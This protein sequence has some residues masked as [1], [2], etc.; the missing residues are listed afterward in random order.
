MI[1][2]FEIKKKNQNLSKY[3]LSLRK[4]NNFQITDCSFYKYS[5][6]H[7][8][9]TICLVQKTLPISNESSISAIRGFQY[10]QPILCVFTKYQVR[11]IPYLNFNE[12]ALKYPYFH[13]IW[14][15]HQ[16]ASAPEESPL[17]ADMASSE[18][19]AMT[20]VCLGVTQP[21]C[22][23]QC[24]HQTSGAVLTS[25]AIFNKLK[26]ASV[27]NKCT[28]ASAGIFHKQLSIYIVLFIYAYMLGWKIHKISGNDFTLGHRDQ[29]HS[30]LLLH[31][32]SLSYTISSIYSQICWGILT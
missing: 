3:P 27:W 1:P 21:N 28:T 8:T 2:F 20:V 22:T 24:N 6:I 31:Y 19:L 30:S 9:K 4:K 23:N 15:T 26:L 12:L 13:E 14:N 25:M 10:I 5:Q 16:T 17:G 7:N 18:W 11:N 32:S 29:H